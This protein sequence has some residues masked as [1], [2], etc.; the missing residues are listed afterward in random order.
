M[1]AN[2]RDILATWKIKARKE[3][4]SLSDGFTEP[5]DLNPPKAK[6]K[7][8]APDASKTDELDVFEQYNTLLRVHVYVKLRHQN[9]SLCFVPFSTGEPFFGSILLENWSKR[10]ENRG[11]EKNWGFRQKLWVKK[12]I[13]YP[14]RPIFA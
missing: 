13:Y 4:K 9:T 6:R 3:I 11:F 12:P 5:V 14:L 1:T 10:V 7:S 2:V 8:I